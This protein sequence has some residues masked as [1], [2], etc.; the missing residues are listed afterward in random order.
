MD[1]IGPNILIRCDGSKSKGYG[2]LYRSISLANVFKEKNYRTLIA[3]KGDR[4]CYHIVNK[5]GFDIYFL[6]E[7]ERN[8]ETEWINRLI[9]LEDIEILILDCRSGLSADFI[10]RTRDKGIYVVCIDDASERRLEA[11]IVFY[12]PVPQVNK[13]NWGNHNVKVRKGWEYVIL[14]EEFS[15]ASQ[16]IR[17]N[18]LSNRKKIVVLVTMGGSDPENFSKSAVEVLYRYKED[19]EIWLVIGKGFKEGKRLIK[20]YKDKDGI[21]IFEDV[22]ELIH[23][24]RKADMAVISFGQTAYEMVTIRVPAIHLCITKDH[25]DSSS[26]FQQRRMAVTLGVY[27]DSKIERL[28]E[29]VAK[30][31]REKDYREE[32]KTNM[33]KVDMTQGRYNVC[34]DIINEFNMRSVKRPWRR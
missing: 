31:C 4:D 18:K 34:N 2:H 9:S 25:A 28:I 12:P 20:D 13:L 11:D 26:I 15:K 22:E 21:R 5:T 10:K 32:L 33:E 1:K 16:E 24:A 23:I 6:D 29:E 3:L 27:D 30:M 17:G 7:K 19:I 14:K 8:Q